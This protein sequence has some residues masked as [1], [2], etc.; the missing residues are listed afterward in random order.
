MCLLREFESMENL[1]ERNFQQLAHLGTLSRI[2]SAQEVDELK[3]LSKQASSFHKTRS[4]KEVL[5]ELQLE[6]ELR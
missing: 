4:F 6:Q 2:L 1:L 3:Q 5:E